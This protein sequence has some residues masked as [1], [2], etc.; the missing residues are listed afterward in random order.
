MSVVSKA[1]VDVN[2]YKWVIPKSEYRYSQFSESEYKRRWK[3]VKDFMSR[4]GFSVLLVNGGNIFEPR[5][6]FN[7]KWLSNYMGTLS[8]SSYLVIPIEGEPMI[9]DSLNCAQRP[10]RRA[11]SRVDLVRGGDP[12]KLAIER[13]K[14]LK[15][16]HGTIGVVE[17]VSETFELSDYNALV[18][19]L[20]G[21]KFEFV[22]EEFETFHLQKSPEEIDAV[23]RAADITDLAV[24]ALIEKAKPGMKEYELFAIVSNAYMEAGAEYP[25]MIL[26]ASQSTEHPNTCMGRLHPI[27]RTLK[28]GDIIITEIGTREERSYEAQTGRPICLGEPTKEFR[29]MYDACLEAYKNCSKVFRPGCTDDEVKAAARVVLDRGFHWE[30]PILH[31]M[32]PP[33]IPMTTFKGPRP[34]IDPLKEGTIIVLETSACRHDLSAG[35]MLDDTF[36]VTSG[37]NRR[38]NKLAPDLTII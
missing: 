37:G 24:R 31:G 22:T 11:R 29:Q 20:P 36:V 28:K 16:D 10:D 38:L 15:L 9:S 4:K 8:T 13:I 3:L 32:Q 19:G 12:V 23:E 18:S 33:G 1:N 2:H 6:W 14:E 27:D 26:L 34:K 30:T 21:V 17:A 35:L 5:G 7:L 25:S